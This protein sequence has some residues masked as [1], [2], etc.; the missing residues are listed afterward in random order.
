MDWLSQLLSTIDP[1]QV[2]LGALVT[3]MIISILRGWVVP[4]SVHT[5]RIKDK[6]TQILALSGER[7][8]WKFAA[9]KSAEAR[10]ELMKQNSDLIDGADTTNR[11]LESLR[12]QIERN[13]DP[14][15]PPMRQI[16]G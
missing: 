10:A 13:G 9:E 16:E 14:N 7:D 4:K 6:D 2:G 11:L 1:T 3:V 12:N 5:D 8:D 15:R